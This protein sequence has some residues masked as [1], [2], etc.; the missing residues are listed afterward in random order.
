MYIIKFLML[1]KDIDSMLSRNKTSPEQER[2]W[3]ME[4]INRHLLL[5]RF[6]TAYAAR[7]ER[8]CCTFYKG[9]IIRKCKM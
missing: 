6:L 3:G 9:N 2:E 5:R 4:S 8:L 1:I 7:S